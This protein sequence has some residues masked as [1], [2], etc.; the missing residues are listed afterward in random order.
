MAP[1]ATILGNIVSSLRSAGL[2]A[3]VTLGPEGSLTTVPRATVTLDGLENIPCDDSPS[4]RWSRLLARVTVHTRSDD[5]SESLTRALDLAA[6][7][8]DA[9]L[10]DPY[11]SQTCC[12][13]PIGRATEIGRIEVSRNLKRPEAEASLSVRCHFETEEA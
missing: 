2:F 10:T 1:A 3:A 5:A 6:A 7:A 12:D 11:R 13:L 9:L 8:R 4:A